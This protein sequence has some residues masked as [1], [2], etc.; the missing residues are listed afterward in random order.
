MIFENDVNTKEEILAKN[1]DFVSELNNSIVKGF[2]QNHISLMVSDFFY[3]PMSSHVPHIE[4]YARL[5]QAKPSIWL[6]SLHVAILTNSSFKLHNMYL[7]LSNYKIKS[8]K[9]R[10]K[11]GP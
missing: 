11:N 8:S 2:E 10:K 3:L 1:F 5:L 4:I 9:G 7:S 6:S